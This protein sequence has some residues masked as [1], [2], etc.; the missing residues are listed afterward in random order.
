[1]A[2]CGYCNTSI[3]FG[4]VKDQGVKYYNED[5]HASGYFMALANQMSPEAI[6]RFALDLKTGACPKCSKR[7]V[8]VD[9]YK[10][11][12]IWS[13]VILSSW[14]SY[15]ELSC[16]S[17]ATKRQVGSILFCGVFGWW[18]FPRGILGTPVQIFRNF[19]SMAAGPK[20]GKPSKLLLNHVKLMTGQNLARDLQ[21]ARENAPQV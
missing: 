16:R 14:G 18:G 2:K 13:A 1:M 8:S 5:C 10:A 15:P 11:H 19:G 9:V 17:C 7:G 20:S 12:R 6:E 4:G 3:L 21:T